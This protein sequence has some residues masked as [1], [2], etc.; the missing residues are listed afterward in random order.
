MT[1]REGR[2][3]GTGNAPRT[4]S[5]RELSSSRRAE[6][7]GPSEAEVGAHAQL[8]GDGCGPAR[9]GRHRRAEGPPLPASS[10][11]P[12]PAPFAP[13]V[14]LCRLPVQSLEWPGDKGAPEGCSVERGDLGWAGWREQRFPD[15]NSSPAAPEAARVLATRRRLRVPRCAPVG[16]HNLRLPIPPFPHSCRI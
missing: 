1:G 8:P 2:M 16:Q 7:A 10:A 6:R 14:P 13:S 15:P 4:P 9:E 11:L 5:T 3:G 12:A